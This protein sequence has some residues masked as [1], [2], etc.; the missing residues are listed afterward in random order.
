MASW[1]P[2]RYQRMCARLRQAR[3]EAQ[4]SQQQVADRLSIPQQHVSRV[5]TGERRIDP[6]ELH[7]FARLYKKPILF[8]LE[9]E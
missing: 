1:H 5:E 2:E 6:V 4:L 7:D 9:E 3:D 8:F